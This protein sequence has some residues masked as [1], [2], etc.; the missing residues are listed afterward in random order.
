MSDG[1]RDRGPDGDIMIAF[2]CPS[3]Q[4]ATCKYLSKCDPRYNL[5][6]CP[7]VKEVPPLC[8]GVVPTRQLAA[9]VVMDEVGTEWD[10]PITAARARLQARSARRAAAPLISTDQRAQH[11][12]DEGVTEFS[13]YVS[14]S[15]G[16]RMIPCR[17][18]AVVESRTPGSGGKIPNF[19][20][21]I[22]R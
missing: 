21:N 19:I 16:G 11:T 10:N 7:G 12:A 2:M 13:A 5:P 9:H 20:P 1:Q 14:K 18:P 15:T 4:R 17:A 8:A 6:T 22:S 3:A